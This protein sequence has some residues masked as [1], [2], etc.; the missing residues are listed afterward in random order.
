MKIKEVSEKTNLTERAIRLYIENELVKPNISESYSGRRNISF[1]SEDVERLKS[2]SILRKAGFSIGQIKLMQ[3]QPEK[4]KEVLREFIDEANKRIKSDSELVACLMPLLSKQELNSQQI[5]RCLDTPETNES[6]LPVEDSEPTPVQKLIRKL[7]LCAGV[8]GFIISAIMCIPIVKVELRDIGE[9]LYPRY[10]G[11][12]YI[13]IFVM[14]ALVLP[15][16]VILLSRKSSV[17]NRKR[18]SIKT[19][20]SVILLCACCF[21]MYFTSAVSFLA[22]VS[23]PEGYVVSYTCDEENYMVFDADEAETV[24]A[25]FLPE[26]LQGAKDVKY[27]YYYKDTRVS[28]EPARTFVFLEMTLEKEDLLKT[29]E[30]YKD[31]RLSDSVSEPWEEIKADWTVIVYRQ[32]YEKAESNYTPLFAF[33]E[34]ENKVRFICEYG[35][36]SLKGALSWGGLIH[37]YEW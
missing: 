8:F 25:E 16:A 34:K 11:R 12:E 24:M 14:L 22:S 23:D 18:I 28:H 6:R 27:E 26:N 13:F 29:V 35:R 36:V 20:V 4:S 3:L 5:S 7:L 17:C 30:R 21:C 9:Y 15:V 10:I 32:A 33:N 1:S 19:V 37:G 2:I 31:F